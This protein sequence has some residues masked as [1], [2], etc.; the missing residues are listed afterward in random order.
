MNSPTDVWEGDWRKRLLC[1]FE[2]SGHECAWAYLAG[3]PAE[4]YS[5]IAAKL[6]DDIA[7][8]QIEWL[9]IEEAREKGAMKTF[10]MDSLARDL[11]HFLPTG[12]RSSARDDFDTARAFATWSTRLEQAMPELSGTTTAIWNA[13]EKQ[14]PYTGWIPTGP[15]DSYIQQAF[16]LEWP[17]TLSLRK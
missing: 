5:L 14:I 3:H 13:I 7:P 1:R 17:E 2:N 16:L 12:W 4:P 9:Q 11:K 15:N 10:A 8:L 6:G